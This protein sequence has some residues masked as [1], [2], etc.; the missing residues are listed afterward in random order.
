[1]FRKPQKIIQF[2]IPKRSW[3]HNIKMCLKEVMED[4]MGG[5]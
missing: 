3:E 4:N 1:M 5:A 2:W